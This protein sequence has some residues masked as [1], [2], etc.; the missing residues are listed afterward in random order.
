MYTYIHTQHTHIQEV[1]GGN[2]TV[3]RFYFETL[4][5]VADVTRW[6]LTSRP[7]PSNTNGPNENGQIKNDQFDSSQDDRIKV[8]LVTFCM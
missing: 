7:R 3:Q 5:S 2:V 1:N 6:L 4:P 8:D